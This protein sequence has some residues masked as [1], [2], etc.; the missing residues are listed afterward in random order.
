MRKAIRSVSHK[1]DTFGQSGDDLMRPF[2]HSARF[3]DASNV[4][5]NVREACWLKVH[6][7]WW[8]GQSFGKPGNSAITDRADVAQFLGK[9]YIGSQLT[10]KRL[11]NCINCPVITQCAA[12]PLVDFAT[13]EASIVNWTMRDSWPRIC[14]LGKVAFMGDTHYLFHQSERGRDLGCSRQKRNDP[15]HFLLYAVSCYEDRKE[16]EQE[17]EKNEGRACALQNADCL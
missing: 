12:H 14:F 6:H 10:Q 4:I 15:D 11:V 13:R 17:T 5:E 1:F 7:L 3:S 16:P 2:R 9:N 8:T